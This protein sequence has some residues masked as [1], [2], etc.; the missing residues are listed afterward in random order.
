M[1]ELE[2][3]EVCAIC[4]SK[5][6]FLTE[7]SFRVNGISGCGHKFCSSCIDKQFRTKVHFRCPKCQK[8]V[9]REQLAYKEIEEVEYER[10]CE[11]RIQIKK[12]FNKIES[13]FASIEEFLDYEEMV[14]DI[15]YTIVKNEDPDKVKE[16]IA[17]IEQYKKDNATTIRRNA[18]RQ[19]DLARQIDDE[20]TIEESLRKERDDEF[21]RKLLDE[22]KQQEKIRKIQDAVA[23]GVSFSELV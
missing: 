7:R 17:I 18:G 10:D 3:S 19:Q 23:L 16:A 12:I 14:E 13:D 1:N 11:K 5:P 8:A 4:H 2:D 15:I 20:I 6:D 9:R 21:Q 22:M